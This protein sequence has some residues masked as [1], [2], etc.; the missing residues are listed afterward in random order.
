[1]RKNFIAIREMI[2][3]L[4]NDDHATIKELLDRISELEVTYGT[5]SDRFKG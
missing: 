4:G 3:N 1:M 2:K 5:E